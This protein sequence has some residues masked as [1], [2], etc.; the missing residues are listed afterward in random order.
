MY[1]LLT[2]AC[3]FLLT[4]FDSVFVFVVGSLPPL[5]DAKAVQAPGKLIQKIMKALIHYKVG[6]YL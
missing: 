3:V 4:G 2:V 6:P 1:C 5:N